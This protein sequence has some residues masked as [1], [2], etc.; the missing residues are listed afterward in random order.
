MGIPQEEIPAVQDTFGNAIQAG[1]AAQAAQNKLNEAAQDVAKKVASLDPPSGNPQG[2]E[3][4]SAPLNNS[5]D[6]P[7]ATSLTQD[8]ALTQAAENFREAKDKA[9]QANANAQAQ[10]SN[11]A[12]ALGNAQPPAIAG[13]LPNT[14]NPANNVTADPKG[15]STSNVSAGPKGASTPNVSAGPKGAST[16]N[17]SAKAGNASPVALGMVQMGKPYAMGTDGPNTFSCTG[18]MR[19][20]ARNLGLGEL[21]WAPSAYLSYPHREGAPVAGDIGVWGDGVGMWTGSDVLMAN[22]LQGKVTTVSLSALGEPI[23]WVH[24]W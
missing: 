3:A 12:K 15:A 19:W 24:P 18:L 2:G 14:L 20:I 5:G 23:A 9:Q 4:Q 7:L 1:N 10:G 11:L 13:G 8:P 21:P 22:E 6:A 17:T 16:P